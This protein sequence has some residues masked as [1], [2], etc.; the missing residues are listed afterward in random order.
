MGPKVKTRKPKIHGLI[1]SSPSRASR[2]RKSDM[3]SRCARGSA[4]VFIPCSLIPERRACDGAPVLTYTSKNYRSGL[5][6]VHD[7]LDLRSR[8]VKERLIRLGSAGPERL[9]DLCKG[10][11][12]LGLPPVGRDPAGHSVVHQILEHLAIRNLEQFRVAV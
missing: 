3:R 11:L 2:R 6:L 9:H 7:R 5:G 8:I 10:A 1:Q 12:G 4:D